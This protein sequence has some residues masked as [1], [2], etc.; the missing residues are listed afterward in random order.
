MRLPGY[1]H[2]KKEPFQTRLIEINPE[3]V[4]TRAQIAEA[5]GGL[6]ESPKPSKAKEEQAQS[7]TPDL[8]RAILGAPLR[9]RPS[10]CIETPLG[11]TQ[12]IAATW[13]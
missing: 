8:G 6:S 2:Q 9:E 1:W 5:L 11:A 12:R 3:A 13:F 4:Y 10:A 7:A